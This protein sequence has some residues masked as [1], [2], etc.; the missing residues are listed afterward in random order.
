MIHTV[1]RKVDSPVAKLRLTLRPA[2]N[3]A[4]EKKMPGVSTALTTVLTF[5]P[6]YQYM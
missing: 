3:M 5:K 2:R 1:W 4:T 6:L